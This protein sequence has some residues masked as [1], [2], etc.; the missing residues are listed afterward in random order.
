MPE[1]PL[2]RCDGCACGPAAC[3]L[4]SRLTVDSLDCPGGGSSVSVDA[5]DGWDG[6]CAALPS[7]VAPEELASIVYDPPA[8]SPCAPSETPEPPLVAA[9]FVRVCAGDTAHE[10]PGFTACMQASSDGTCWDGH[11]RHE[12]FE[13]LIDHRACAPC[14]CGPPAGGTCIAELLL[15]GDGACKDRV[16]AA[17]SAGLG[18][19][20]CAGIRSSLPLSAVRASLVEAAPG[21]CSPNVPAVIGT[22]ERREP[23]VVCSFPET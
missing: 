9:R 17:L 21:A 5:G 22:L 20:P 7:P 2:D 8:L 15:Y 13:E 4:P 3:E 14:E 1:E 16:G 19:T 18:E 6:T 12:F 23:H 10:P 11:T